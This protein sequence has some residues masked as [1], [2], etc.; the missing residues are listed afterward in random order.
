LEIAH[1]TGFGSLRQFNRACREIFRASPRALRAKRRKADR[2]VADGG[3]PLRLA[4][5][6]PLDWDALIA[7]FAAR[8]IRG[9]EHVSK[10][11]YRRTILVDGD[12]GV[13]E[14]SPGGDDHL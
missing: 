12:P 4:F 13:I 11:T 8:A 1:A 3:L 7:Y 5:R 2:L 9:V 6:G 10:A 14:L